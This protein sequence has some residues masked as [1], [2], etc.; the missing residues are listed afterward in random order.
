M[1]NTRTISVLISILPALVTLEAVA[2][3]TTATVNGITN[4]A[5][6]ESVVACA[7]ATRPE[8][9]ADVK[10]MGFAS[11]VNLRLPTEA[12]ADLDAEAAAAKAARLRYFHIP[13]NGASPDPAAA[14]QFLAVMRDKGNEPAFVHC[15]RGNRAAA[16]WM[17][18]R[19]LVDG[20]PVD[21]AAE[22][23]AAL[24]LKSA[25]LEQFAL[26]YIQAHRR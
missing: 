13:M 22:E 19:A 25:P 14:D 9:M 4:L 20:W 3:V 16:M 18:K 15:A 24:G 5:K 2:Q 7:G 10:K 6:V 17:I 26:D 1:G 12:G 23:A 8:A 11:V 21:R